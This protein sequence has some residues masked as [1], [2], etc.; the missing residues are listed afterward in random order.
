[1]HI[2]P[3]EALMLL[4]PF[5]SFMFFLGLLACQCVKRNHSKQVKAGYWGSYETTTSCTHTGPNIQCP[6][7][8]AD[9]KSSL[10]GNA[11]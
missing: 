4:V 1:M 9:P 8:Y 2:G 5:L 7:I 6:K 10:A 3:L 11:K